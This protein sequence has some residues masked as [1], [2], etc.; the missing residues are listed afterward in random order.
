MARPAKAVPAVLLVLLAIACGSTGARSGE[1]PYGKGAD[2]VWVFRPAH[3]PRSVVVFVHGHGGPGEDTPQY[4][5]PWLR[6]LVASGSAVLHPRYELYPGAHGTV[7]HIVN[8]VRI[9]MKTLG[10]P[11][12]PLVGIGYSRGARLVMDWASR[13]AGTPLAPRALLSVFPASG[14]DPEE[15]LSRIA[16][17]TPILVLVGDRDEV[18]GGLGAR[19]LLGDL[20]AAGS[21]PSNVGLEVVH[22]H[23]AFVASHLSV[24]EDSPGARSAFWNRAD[25]LIDIVAPT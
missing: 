2:E 22:S 16:R 12:A 17:R 24:L 18:V 8:A 19:A 21:V 6:H 7:P 4:H 14:A 1:G 15:D 23:G 9:G 20:E 3:D 25:G 11:N 13:A 10:S 5:L